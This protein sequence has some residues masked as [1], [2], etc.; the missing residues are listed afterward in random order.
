MKVLDRNGNIDANLLQK[1]VLQSLTDDVKFRQVDSAKKRAVK[2]SA[3]YEEFKARVSCAHMKSLTRDEVLSLRDVKKGWSVKKSLPGAKCVSL[4][5]LNDVDTSL[6]PQQSE[7]KTLLKQ[8]TTIEDLERSLRKMDKDHQKLAYLI[9]LSLPQL[10]ALMST[11]ASVDVFDT[12][13]D[14]L[15]NQDILSHSD[16]GA[17]APF[18][19]DH[20]QRMDWIIGLTSLGNFGLLCQFI[21]S[22]LK[23]QLDQLISFLKTDR[24]ISQ[25]KIDMIRSRYKLD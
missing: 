12:V 10:I 2:T 8:P 20:E 13:L 3:T 18:I 6:F 14:L 11:G 22:Q 24:S 25:E 4:S 5:L 17:N 9:H 15:T 19:M 16:D 21:S 7:L 23:R 1:E